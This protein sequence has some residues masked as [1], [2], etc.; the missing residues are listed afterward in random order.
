MSVA[1][2]SPK[3]RNREKADFEQKIDLYTALLIDAV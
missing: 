3:K 2:M 1:K